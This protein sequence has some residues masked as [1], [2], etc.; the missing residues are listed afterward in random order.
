VTQ[1]L[2][3]GSNLKTNDRKERQMNAK[4]TVRL[5]VL[6]L[7]LSIVVAAAPIQAAPPA[8]TGDKWCEGMHIRALIG[9]P[10]GDAFA[11][12]LQHGVE[13][14]RDDLGPTVDIIYSNWD[15]DLLLRQAREAIAIQPDGMAIN[16][17]PGYDALKSL[18]KDARDDGIL[19]NL[20]VVDTGNVHKEFGAGFF[21]VADPYAQGAAM[22]D[23][24]VKDFGLQAGD[25]VLVMG[26]W[27]LDQHVRETGVAETFEKAGCVVDQITITHGTGGINSDPNQLTP[28]LTAYQ[29][30]HPETKVWS[31]QGGIT[32][33][34]GP[35]YAQ[36]AGLEPGDVKMIGFDLN[37]S[38]ISA[39]DKGYVQIASDQQPYLTGYESIA[40]LCL[41]WK[42]GFSAFDVETGSGLV[43]TNN[44]K[45]VAE[46]AKMGIR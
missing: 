10:E 39:F 31:F 34:Q 30:A 12:L 32:L 42:Y 4:A 20:I 21:G 3:A 8:Q 16:G 18:V 29:L 26:A 7:V 43:D 2:R 46:L 41:S 5:L 17:L 24:A 14:A 11:S 13:R 23:K 33:A 36:A 28:I 27:D 44:Y 9:G 45:S 6:A 1:N 15:S 25:R 40:S 37:E 38:V 22:A 35:L 19:V